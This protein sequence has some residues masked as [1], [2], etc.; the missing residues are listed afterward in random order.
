M[1]T[2]SSTA[3]VPAWTGGQ[4]SLYRVLFGAYLATHFA[5]LLPHGR[6]LF[7][8]EGVLPDGTASPL[9][10]LFPNLFL[11]SD[12]PSFVAA[13]LALGVLAS[14]AFLVGWRDRLAAVVLWVIWGS[15][16]GRNPLISNPSLPYVG[17]LLLIHA[18]LPSAPYGSLAMRGRPD[19]GGDWHLPR[20]LHRVAWI[21]MSVGYSF[22]G[23]TKLVSPSWR[24]G[25]ALER[26]LANPLARPGGLRL[27]LLELP[28]V[29]LR[30]AT[31]GALAFELA[32]VLLALSRRLRPLA[33]AAMLAMHLALI[34]L[35][36][37]A[38]LSIAMVFLH[39]FTFD[40]AW[41]RAKRASEP[42]EIYYDGECGLCHRAVRFALA[43]DPDGETFRFAPLQGPTFEE[44]VNE[45]TRANLPDSI[46]L[47]TPDGALLDRS[48]A[49]GRMLL[50][51]GGL[52][53]LLGHLLLLVPRVLRDT[54]YDGV[55]RIRKRIFAKPEGLCP[56]VPPAIG[57]RFLP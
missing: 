38:D 29:L 26:V 24:N 27:A 50:A 9:L 19:P 51:L 46:L 43:E 14:L 5:Q 33:W 13:V 4:Y 17:L 22:S 30:L 37:F 52:W 15:L 20:A 54:G 57:R 56:I 31:W 34:L 48:S 40:P 11:L 53:R 32:F 47:R 16:F 55:A 12:A 25:T 18:G 3:R 39:L 45:E 7:S 8:S 35:I 6:E 10:V 49:V 41:V 23:A 1:T 36:D 2:E 42:L 28:E 44:R 21:L